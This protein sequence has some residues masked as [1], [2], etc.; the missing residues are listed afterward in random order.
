MRDED[1]EV[2]HGN[3]SKTNEGHD[4]G[5]ELTR[6]HKQY[7]GT[8]RRRSQE[9]FSFSQGIKKLSRRWL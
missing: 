7:R 5:F 8:A 1:L 2:D 3:G 6:E 4:L 9:D